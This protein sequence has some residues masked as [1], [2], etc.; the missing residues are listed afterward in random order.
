MIP[1][2]APD[3]P[4]D[5]PVTVVS[6]RGDTVRL[7]EAVG[8]VPGETALFVGAVAGR[9][10]W[11]LD[12]NDPTVDTAATPGPPDTGHTAD[13]GAYTDLMR[14]YAEVGEQ[15]WAAAGRAVQLVEWNRN[16][17]F[18]GR[19]ATPTVL[20][21][22]ERAR[23]CPACG[24]MA[25]PRLAPAV[26]TLVQRD[27]GRALLA[28]NARWPTAMYSCLAGFVEPGETVEAALIREVREEVG[29]DVGEL[30]YF[31]SQPWPFPHSLML[32]F[33]ARYQGGEIAVDGEEISDAAW[34][35]PDELPEVPGPISIGRRLIDDWVE[36]PGG[37]AGWGTPR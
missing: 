37:T 4:P 30:R 13:G 5:G 35:S 28:R 1:G 11:A 22:G 17:R 2:L 31:S 33:H 36:G 16:H 10:W 24:L 21:P 15:T 23:R 34:F 26:I 29:V 19:C 25:F 7:G 32:G 9:H 8:F 6:V 12:A 14:L 3:G 27:D 18:C 20:A